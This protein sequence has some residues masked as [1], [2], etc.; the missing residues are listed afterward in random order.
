MATSDASRAKR[1]IFI[2]DGVGLVCS[3][4]SVDAVRW[5]LSYPLRGFVC[6]M[7]PQS[8]YV[9]KYN[10]SWRAGDKK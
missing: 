2:L 7:R 8:K 5:V 9:D 3:V 6:V 10:R 1:K 4:G